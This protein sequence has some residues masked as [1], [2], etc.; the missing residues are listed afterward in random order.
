MK[1]FIN[2]KGKLIDLSRP[3]IMG[4]LNV[5]P[6]SFYDGGQYTSEKDIL[7][8]VEKMLK[9]GA[10]FI[11]VGA[12]SSRPNANDV[13]EG[14]ELYRS[15]KAINL[16]TKK[17]PE[18]LISVDTFRSKVAQEA[19]AAGA[20]MINDISGGSLDK[21]MFQTVASLQVPYILMHMQGTP[22][23]MQN[24]P[25][26][27]DIIFEIRSYFSK[28]INLLRQLGLNDIILDVGFGFGKTIEHNYTLLKNL[29]LF[30]I[31]GVPLL[32]GL[33]R[34]SMLYKVLDTN[35]TKAL[36]ATSVANTLALQNGASILRV[37]DVKEAYETIQIVNQL[38]V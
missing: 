20:C 14:Q 30:N 35:A 3:K 26:Y 1:Q 29:N 13:S 37:H 27:E 17:F 22:Q 33:S 21:N 7:L 23:N 16:I 10:T 36:N 32:A 31:F 12:Y 2:C 25:Y 19:V 38:A 9:D 24:N 15:L 28:K 5:T 8:K 34:K 11:D 4:I 18:T 6:D